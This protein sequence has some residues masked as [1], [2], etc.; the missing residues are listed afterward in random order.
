M[1]TDQNTKSMPALSGL[2]A[3]DQRLKF[4]SKIVFELLRPELVSFPFAAAVKEGVLSPF[5]YECFI[6]QGSGLKSITALW[7]DEESA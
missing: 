2:Y 1:L 3:I 4:T 5:W 6:L 7:K